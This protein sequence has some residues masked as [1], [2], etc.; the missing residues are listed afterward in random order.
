MNHISSGVFWMTIFIGLIGVGLVLYAATQLPRETIR[1]DI[2]RDLG[3]A[4]LIAAIVSIAYELNTRSILDVERL[5][6]VLKTVLASNVPPNVW[7]QVNDEILQ[8][9][10]IRKNVD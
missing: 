6:G 5:E 4:L 9:H 1:R 2:V 7:H 8:R 10:V 3:I